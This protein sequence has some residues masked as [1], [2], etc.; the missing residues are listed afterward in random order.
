MEG[1]QLFLIRHAKS[2]WGNFSLPDFD[3]PLN[4]RGKRDAPVMARRLRDKKIDID[5]FISSPAKR[6]RKTAALFAKEYNVN[7]EDILLMPALYEANVN[8]FF[9][10]ISNTDNKYNSIALFSHNNGITDFANQLTD[11]IIDSIPACG[12]FAIKM[13]TEDWIHFNDAKKTF[14]FFDCPKSGAD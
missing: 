13:D 1:K 10:V 11:I 12:I 2:D 14:W 4:E 6:A 9:E 8:T 5:V 7:K 3:R